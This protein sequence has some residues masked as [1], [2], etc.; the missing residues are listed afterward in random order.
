MFASKN[1]SSLP[2]V[3]FRILS[4]FY[5]QE[6]APK[7][8]HLKMIDEVSLV[9]LL[10]SYYIILK[11]LISKLHLKYPQISFEILAYQCDI[12]IISLCFWTMLILTYQ[13]VS[14]SSAN[15][16][17]LGTSLGFRRAGGICDT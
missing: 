10:Y 14:K 6:K 4:S 15:T 11:N 7:L 2:G 13:V 17:F 3:Y 5:G 12:Y 1:K 8:N 16:F 9:I